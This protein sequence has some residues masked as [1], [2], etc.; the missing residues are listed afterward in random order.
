ML[1][2]F[3]RSPHDPDELLLACVKSNIG[4]EPPAYAFQI[5]VHEFADVG[6]VAYLVGLGERG[7][8]L[9]EA[10]IMIDTTRSEEQPATRRAEA[11]AF[12]V[13]Y[14]RSGPRLAREL[15]EDAKQF[16]HSW[17]TVL[18]AAKELG[19]ERPAGGPNSRW[20]LPAGLLAEL[21]EDTSNG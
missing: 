6:E 14:L 7:D 16:G 3:G 12:V 15:K 8:S 19:V 5:D 11:S 10:R 9:A 20:E 17:A 2:L 21:G 18:R 4:P 13:T 1:F